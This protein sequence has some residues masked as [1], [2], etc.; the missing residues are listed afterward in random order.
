MASLPGRVCQHA[1]AEEAYIK[2]VTG[3]SALPGS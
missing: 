3:R 2:A 1:Q